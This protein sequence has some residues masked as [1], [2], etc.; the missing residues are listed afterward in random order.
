M[1]V[2]VGQSPLMCLYPVWILGEG[3]F[4]GPVSVAQAFLWA[5][6]GTHPAAADNPAIVANSYSSVMLPVA[7]L[8]F[9]I[10]KNNGPS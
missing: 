6:L 4:T 9:W 5:G 3:P 2:Y 10:A 8:S 1:C 7:F